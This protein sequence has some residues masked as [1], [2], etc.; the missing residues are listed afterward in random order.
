MAGVR[1]V[2]ARGLSARA[3]SHGCDPATPCP[4]PA[5]GAGTIVG[6]VDLLV[7]LFC[8]AIVAVGAGFTYLVDT[9]MRVEERFVHAVVIGTIVVSTVGFAVAGSPA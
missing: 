7:V 8:C 3:R 2:P 5:V 4:D 9:P 6:A 1:P